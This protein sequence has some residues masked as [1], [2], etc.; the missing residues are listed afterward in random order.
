M[1]LLSLRTH[2][3]PQTSPRTVPERPLCSAVAHGSSEPLPR[4]ATCFD[5]LAVNAWLSQNGVQAWHLVVWHVWILGHLSSPI[6]EQAWCRQTYKRGAGRSGTAGER[7][8]TACSMAVPV[9]MMAPPCGSGCGI[10]VE[11]P[12]ADPKT[13]QMRFGVIRFKNPGRRPKDRAE[14]SSLP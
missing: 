13:E 7:A 6:F 10:R 3:C 14:V 2:D 5:R 1:A 4:R 12:G 8:A 9:R 11:T